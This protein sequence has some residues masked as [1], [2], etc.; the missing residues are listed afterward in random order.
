MNFSNDPNNPLDAQFGYANAAL[1]VLSRYTQQSKFV[2]GYYVYWNREWYVQD[3]WKV[4][5]RLTLDYGLRFVNQQP[6]HDFYGHSSNFFPEQWSLS[7]APRLYQPGC[8]GGVYP[9]PT[10]RQAMDPRTGQLLGPASAVRIGQLVPGTGDPAQGLIQQGQQGISE[11]GYVWPTVGYAPRIGAAYDL[12]GQ[13]KVVVRGGMGVFF[14]RPP[15]DSVQNL[16]SNPPFSRGVTLQAVRVQDLATAASGPL[17][18]TQIFAYQYET[19]LPSSAQWTGGVQLALPWA[20]ALDVSYVGQHAWNQQNATGAGANGQNVNAVDIGAA[21]LPDNQDPTLAPSATPGV[22]AVTADLMRGLRGYSN[23]LQQ[24]GQFWRTYHSI[25]SSFKRRFSQGLQAEVNWTWTLADDGTTT[26]QPR[27]QHAADGTFSLRPDWDEYVELNKGQ[28]TVSHLVRA[29]F[30]WDLPDVPTGSSLAQR[31]LAAVLNDW[32]LSGVFTANSG[33]RYTI[34]FSYQSGGSNVNLTGSPDY[35]ATIRILGDTGS[36]C[37]GN[38]FQ[39]FNTAAFAGPVA[40]STGLESGRFYMSGCKDDT[41]DLALARNFMLGGGRQ[42]QIRLEAFNVF[43]AVVYN[44]RVTSLQL[45]SPTDQTV[46]N[47]QYLADGS[48]DPDRLR[49]RNAGFGAVTGAQAMRSIQLQFRLS[50]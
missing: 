27:Y 22:T 6:Q 46:R 30:V 37:S 29:N 19:G 26:L 3:N 43:N 45:N 20:S 4:N 18:A 38:Q 40:P 8:P 5:N 49:P 14:D 34:G 9:C 32:Q 36:G 11:F 31:S 48:V 23:I 39:Q 1:G 28:G 15:S 21:F 10:T 12:T 16:V 7:N 24:Q 41:T 2:E 13:Q 50:F 42:A 17:P 33:N 25:Q 47:S 44:A 35:P